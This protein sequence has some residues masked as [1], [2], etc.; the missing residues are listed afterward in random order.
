MYEPEKDKANYVWGFFY[1]NPEDKR[2]FLPK[3]NPMMGVQVNFANPKSVL[4]LVALIAFFVFIGFLA[5]KG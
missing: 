1:Y 2:I 4:A 3:P 5:T